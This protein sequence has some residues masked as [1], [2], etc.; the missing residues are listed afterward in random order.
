MLAEIL[1]LVENLPARGRMTRKKYM[2]RKAWI[3][4]RNDERR[5]HLAQAQYDGGKDHANYVRGQGCVVANGDC[6]GD[7]QAAHVRSRGAGGTA[8]DMVGMCWFHHQV[9]QHGDGIKT[10]QKKYGIDLEAEAARLWEEN[11]NWEGEGDSN[12]DDP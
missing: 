12:E 7:V 5:E 9:E 11:D 8:K 1:R 10:F 6:Y 3:R 4:A 2:K